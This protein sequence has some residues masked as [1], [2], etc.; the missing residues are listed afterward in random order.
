MISALAMAG[1]LLTVPYKNYKNGFVMNGFSRAQ[2]RLVSAR[3][4]SV[5]KIVVVRVVSFSPLA[6]SG[7]EGLQ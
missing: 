4:A 3:F 1:A 5:C 2:K 6:V 7:A